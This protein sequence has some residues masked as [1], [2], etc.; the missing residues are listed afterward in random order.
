VG[1]LFF[2]GRAA[3][4][5]GIMAENTAIQTEIENAVTTPQSVSIDGVSKSSRTIAE[6]IAADK[7][8]ANK[9]ARRSANMGL[10]FGVFTPPGHR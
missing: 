4:H 9:E 2:A 10:R 1:F 6:L 8:V 3:A 7:H 5:G